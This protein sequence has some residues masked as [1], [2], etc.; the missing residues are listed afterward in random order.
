MDNYFRQQEKAC[1]STLLHFQFSLMFYS[2]N[3]QNIFKFF[4]IHYSL[5]TYLVSS[6]VLG[7]VDDDG[8][9]SAAAAVVSTT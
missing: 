1:R 4:T 2:F 6:V 8:A 7:V 3:K 5:F 9:G